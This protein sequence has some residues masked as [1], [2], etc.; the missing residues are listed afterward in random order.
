MHDELVDRRRERLQDKLRALTAGN[1]DDF[2][3]LVREMEL[4]EGCDPVDLA[5]AAMRLVWGEAPLYVAADPEPETRS[6]NRFGSG[7][8]S[9]QDDGEFVEIVIPVGSWNRLQPGTIVKA[10]ACETGLPGTVVGRV[11]ILDKVSFVAVPSEHVSRI[12][13]ALKGVNIAG[14]AVYPRLAHPARR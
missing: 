1:L 13:S 7:S 12:M 9:S 6:D 14:R 2:R 5:A 3:N 4:E 8:H 10:I 11:K